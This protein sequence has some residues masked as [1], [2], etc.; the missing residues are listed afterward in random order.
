MPV[1]PSGI[2]PIPLALV[3]SPRDS[4]WHQITE[5]EAVRYVDTIQRDPHQWTGYRVVLIHAKKENPHVL[6]IANLLT[7][8]DYEAGKRHAPA[9]PTALFPEPEP[10]SAL[11]KR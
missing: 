2:V 8:E 1:S 7:S 11:G 6:C 10:I 4:H 9:Q 5:P 3:Y